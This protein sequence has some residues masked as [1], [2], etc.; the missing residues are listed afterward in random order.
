MSDSLR[1]ALTQTVN[2]YAHMPTRVQ[3]LA[4][5]RPQLP[6]LRE[7]NLSH[8]RDLIIA[9]AAQGAQLVM[10][11]E[12]FAGP[13]FALDRRPLWRDLAE[14]IVTG[15]SVR[16]MC[17]AAK[18]C[19]VMVVAPI[20]EVCKKSGK[21]FNTAAV[22]DEQGEV[23]GSYRKT[24]I[25][26]GKNDVAQFTER[27]YYQRS[28]GRGYLQ[29]GKNLSGNGFFPV[30][31]CKRVKLGVAI[32]YDRH[33]DGVMRSLARGGA[34]LVCCPAVT[35]GRKSQRMWPLE[36]QVDAVRHNLFIAM[37][38]RKGTE[39]PFAVEY[40]GDSHVVGPQGRL[41]NISNH[42]KLVIS[43][44]PLAQLRAPDPSGWTL[45]SDR[46]DNIYR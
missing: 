30:F 3:D 46:R 43:D 15:P 2:A 24:H 13:Y 28:D 45:Q 38:N 11:G 32:C 21:R 19:G 35:F 23:L 44:V 37:S 33:F 25:P 6:A 12:L 27:S 9:A 26:E 22:I 8:H 1:I 31:R 40:F 29:A 7:A 41:A 17:A 34:E 4:S 16:A 14:D 5:L 18:Q 20:Y 36:G 39:P 42:P 10:L